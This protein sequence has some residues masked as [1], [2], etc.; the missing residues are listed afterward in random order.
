MR[1]LFTFRSSSE[2]TMKHFDAFSSMLVSCW[3]I[4]DEVNAQVRK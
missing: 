2:G 1:S 3:L 4:Q